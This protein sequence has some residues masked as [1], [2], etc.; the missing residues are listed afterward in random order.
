MFKVFQ[1]ATQNLKKNLKYVM[2][3]VFSYTFDFKILTFKQSFK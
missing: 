2:Y 1:V 3:R